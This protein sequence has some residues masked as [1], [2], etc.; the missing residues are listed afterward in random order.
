MWAL[1]ETRSSMRKQENHNTL[2]NWIDRCLVASLC[3]SLLAWWLVGTSAHVT[4]G[5]TTGVAIH[6]LLLFIEITASGYLRQAKNMLI[7][8]PLFF[9]CSIV[10]RWLTSC[11]QS[12]NTL[13]CPW[14]VS[15]WK[16]YLQVSRD[17]IITNFVTY[18]EQEFSVATISFSSVHCNAFCLITQTNT[19]LRKFMAECVDPSGRAYSKDNLRKGCIFFK[20][21]NLI[22][23]FHLFIW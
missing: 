19:T 12:K 20:Q 16:N 14:Y 7:C 22:Y 15:F 9:W 1:K 8:V 13:M 17:T 6:Y 3:R 2:F 23:H 5:D 10:L 18:V 21:I 11:P 4:S